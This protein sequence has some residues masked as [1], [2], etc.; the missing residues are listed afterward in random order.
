MVVLSAGSSSTARACVGPALKDDSR[1]LQ[2]LPS[3]VYRDQVLEPG[4]RG[5]F[6]SCLLYPSSWWSLRNSI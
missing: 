3:C 6:A 5:A 2:F 1:L 4:M